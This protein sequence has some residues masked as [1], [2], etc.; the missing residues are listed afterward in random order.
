M[1]IFIKNGILHTLKFHLHTLS[2]DFWLN[3]C[4]VQDCS[5]SI[6]NALEL[7]QSCTKQSIVSQFKWCVFLILSLWSVSDHLC[8][9]TQWPTSVQHVGFTS[10]K[11]D[12]HTGGQTGSHAQIHTFQTVPAAG[13]SYWTINLS[14]TQKH[15]AHKLPTRTW[16]HNPDSSF[17]PQCRLWNQCWPKGPSMSLFIQVCANW[18]VQVKIKHYWSHYW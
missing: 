9:Q 8:I 12:R 17:Q 11:P 3:L 7:L 2:C 13:T 14:S 5:N 4:L 6:A 1:G 16:I 18:L 10:V 15:V